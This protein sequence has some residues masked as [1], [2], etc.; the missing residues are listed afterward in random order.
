MYF[1]SIIVF[2]FT[3]LFLVAILVQNLKKTDCPRRQKFLGTALK[4]DSRFYSN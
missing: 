3:G 4:S 2:E 1:L